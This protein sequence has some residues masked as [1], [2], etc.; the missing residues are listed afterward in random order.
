M[1]S[2]LQIPVF[3]EVDVL[4]SG[5][6]SAGVSL[7]LAARA[8]G[9]N[10]F[11]AAARPYLGEDIAGDMLFWPD[12]QAKPV[13]KLAK[14][15]YEQG[16]NPV[17]P[18]HV[19][20]TLEQ[21]MV[22]ADVPFL[23][24]CPPAG[25]L[26]DETGRIRGAIFATRSG[27]LAVT[28]RRVV[29]AS[30]E[31]SL[32]E[33]AGAAIPPPQGKQTVLHTTLTLGEGCAASDVD[34]VATPPV[35]SG[36]IQG[37]PYLLTPRVYRL[38]VDFGHG[39]LRDLARA[40]AE[41]VERCWVPGE[42]QHQERLRLAH[43][44]L[45]TP[46]AN[47]AEVPD[48]DGLLLFSGIAD[49]PPI[50]SMD[51][52]ANLAPELAATLPEPAQPAKLRFDHVRMIAQNSTQDGT[53]EKGRMKTVLDAARTVP[54]GAA[55]VEIPVD[56]LPLLDE[57]EVLVLG[58]GTA[59]APAGISAARAGA[60]TIVVEAT[61]QLG[62]V[63]TA[64]Q[65]AVYWCGNRVG[66]T[67]EIDR[68]VHALEVDDK[69][70]LGKS[71]SVS[72]KSEWY[73][74]ESRAA[75]A[76]LLFRSLCSGVW[77][78]DGRVQGLM[79]ATPRGFG[80]IRAKCV[81][82]SSGCADV[83]AAAGCPTRVIGAE[84]VAVQGTGLAAMQPGKD[85]NNSDH[86]FVDDTDLLNTTAALVSA[87]LK[88]RDHFDAG[89][90]VDSRERRQIVGDIELGPADILAERRFPDTICVATSN[91]DS[92]GYTIH[93]LF[94][95]KAPNKDPLWSDVPLRALLPRGVERVLA[96][97]LGV[98]CHRDALPVIRMQADVQ[99]Q[100][101]AAG[102]LAAA[103]AKTDRDLRDLDLSRI[104]R[105]LVEIGS[106]PERVLTDEETFPVAD[107][108]L[109]KAVFSELNTFRGLALV[110]S[111]PERAIPL[112]REKF[113][114]EPELLLAQI[115]AL[116]GDH[117][118]CPMVQAHLLETPWDEGWDYRGMHQFGFSLSPVDVELICLGRG[119]DADAW[120]VWKA[121]ADELDADAAF[122]HCRALV[123]SAE[124]LYPRHP[125]PVAAQALQRLLELPGMAGHAHASVAEMQA[126]QNDDPN[127][128]SVRNNAL[129]E[130]HLARGLYR[131]GDPEGW[132]EKILL[133]YTRDL[134]AHFARHARAVLG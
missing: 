80:L 11:L 54:E 78:E 42:Y 44:L 131:C 50:Q 83:P 112:L 88:F 92:H 119:G 128:N 45:K 90:L 21:S 51:V 22:R 16:P 75:G 48:V 113:S 39:N 26:R 35:F 106:L 85:Y 115:L 63:G 12:A 65:I 20:L 61:D 77:M 7:A 10:V 101:Y 49:L 118:G 76:T 110:F 87:K 27:P 30:T 62:G 9:A 111:E 133:H 116:L 68:G 94:M 123:E 124:G 64:G 130:L 120:T 14:A 70:E 99:N 66:F 13:S 107:E 102:L 37:K 114:R 71:W 60:D 121:K 82:D 5:G 109:Q 36:E 108:V 23:L 25:L 34:C 134:R 86:N 32:A 91:F 67:G 40:E 43:R 96:T 81:I 19:K 100:G 3:A 95:I 28:A 17:T 55:S 1:M 53:Q 58:G 6:T 31:G 41:I 15:V 8:S 105:Q 117:T 4:V 129:R 126:A 74:R 18:M 79:V 127:D 93:P 97:G 84:H 122:S 47:L 33:A 72:A 89:Q 104:Q 2:T 24:N 125:N 38:E 132:G 103:S 69:F 98:S 56:R 52:S 73:H 57:C 59:G 29:D 46:P